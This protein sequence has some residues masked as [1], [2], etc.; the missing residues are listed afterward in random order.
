MTKRLD[1]RATR[2]YKVHDHGLHIESDLY[3]L[4]WRNDARIIRVLIV[5]LLSGVAS[6]VA[7]VTGIECKSHIAAMDS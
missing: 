5:L 2:E 3:R 6:S 1:L 4:V 7:I